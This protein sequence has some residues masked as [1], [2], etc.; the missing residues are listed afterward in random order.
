MKKENK[1]L[2]FGSIVLLMNLFFGM[3]SVYVYNWYWYGYIY[4]DIPYSYFLANYCGIIIDI[5]ANLFWVLIGF[6]FG[7]L[8]IIKVRETTK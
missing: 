8:C 3:I 6:L 2:L 4:G 5:S 1:I 7:A